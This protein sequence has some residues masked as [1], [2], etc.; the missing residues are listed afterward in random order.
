MAMNSLPLPRWEVDVIGDERD[1]A[2]LREHFGEGAW[3]IYKDEGLGQTLMVVGNLSTNASVDD[4]LRAAEERVKI[5]SGVLMVA[6]D[7]IQPLTVGGAIERT[8]DQ[9][10]KAYASFNIA[11]RVRSFMH[12]EVLRRDASGNLV[13]VPSPPAR[14]VELA[15]LA[16]NDPVVR[17]VMRLQT[18]DDANTWTGLVRLLEVIVE[19]VGGECVVASNDWASRKKLKRFERT[20]NSSA[21]GDASRHG[22]E[23]YHPPPNPMTLDE[24]KALVKKIQEAWLTSRL[25]RAVD[26]CNMT[27]NP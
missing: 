20:A 13:A 14:S 3:S 9:K 23:R 15:K 8:G 19:D 2:H 4:V 27:S 22:H 10:R 1:L 25:A 26:T 21:S 17:R 12:A 5:L 7:A 18:V 6:N 11:V 24:G 16:M